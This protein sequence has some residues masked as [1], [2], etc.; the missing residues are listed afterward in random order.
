MHVEKIMAYILGAIYLAVYISIYLGLALL[1]YY[2]AYSIIEPSSF[3]GVVGVFILGSIIVPLTIGV[4]VLTMGGLFAAFDK[5]KQNI[6]KERLVKEEG[7]GRTITTITPLDP[8]LDHKAHSKRNAIILALSA[9]IVIGVISLLVYEQNNSSRYISSEESTESDQIGAANDVY[10][11]ELV[12][13]EIYDPNASYSSEINDDYSEMT[14]AVKNVLSTL[15]QSGISGVAKSVRDCYVNS[16][17]SRLYCVYLDNAARVLDKSVAQQMGFTRNEYLNDDRA[18]QR[19]NQYFYIPSKSSGLA[20]V[21]TSKIENELINLF[22]QE[23]ESQQANANLGE[24]PSVD[25]SAGNHDLG[26]TNSRLK[27]ELSQPFSRAVEEDNKVEVEA[28]THENNLE[29]LN[30][31][32]ESD[33]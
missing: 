2:I 7:I 19:A 32:G 14:R 16:D 27:Q 1:P 30:T 4:A 17:E 13:E 28:V 23:F 3:G 5:V 29:D 33:E 25:V 8:P 12:S 18:S 22:S 26:D 10:E 9:A 24:E 11:E 6:S 31:F 21:H 20:D 15:K